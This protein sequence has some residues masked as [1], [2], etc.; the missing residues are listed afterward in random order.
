MVEY[1]REE[2]NIQKKKRKANDLY[3]QRRIRQAT[4][5]LYKCRREIM[6]DRRLENEY[7]ERKLTQK[8]KQSKENESKTEKGKENEVEKYNE[9]K[10]EMHKRHCVEERHN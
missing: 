9:R 4:A 6:N 8:G 7:N 2:V 3:R 10:A 5:T 1:D